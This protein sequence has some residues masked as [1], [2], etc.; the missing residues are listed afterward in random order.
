MWS[1]SR[2]S[3]QTRRNLLKT[4]QGKRPTLLFRLRAP[5]LTTL[6]RP[7]IDLLSQTLSPLQDFFSPSNV[8]RMR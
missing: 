5:F 1:L 4:K 8:S 7:F 3:E 6:K 2:E